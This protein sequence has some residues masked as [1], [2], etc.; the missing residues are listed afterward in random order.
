MSEHLF[1]DPR[2]TCTPSRQSS[3][4]FASIVVHAVALLAILLLE[5]VMPG[6]LPTPHIAALAWSEPRM[7]KLADIPLP[8]QR[9]T[10]PKTPTPVDPSVNAAPLV[11]PTGIA[12]EPEAPPPVIGPPGIVSGP[13]NVDLGAI[14]A[15]PPPPPPPQAAPPVRLHSGID[16]PVKIRDVRPEYPTIARTAGVKGLVIIEATIDTSGEVVGTRVL[17]SVPLLDEAALN[18]VRQWKYTPAKLN[19]EPVS[20]LIT[21]TVNFTLGQ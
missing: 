6:V 17:R 1:T 16:A 4:V 12:P 20:V 11:A 13:A 2:T 15:P 7:V 19:G 10:V 8:P 18:A 21:V 14:V 3:L 9:I 5:I